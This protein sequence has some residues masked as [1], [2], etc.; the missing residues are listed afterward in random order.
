M[1]AHWIYLFVTNLSAITET[2]HTETD[3]D[4]LEHQEEQTPQGHLKVYP[5]SSRFCN[6]IPFNI[7]FLACVNRILF[8]HSPVHHGKLCC[9]HFLTAPSNATV[10]RIVQRALWDTACAFLW[11]YAPEWNYCWCALPLRILS[12]HHA[13]FPCQ[14]YCFPFS[15]TAHACSD[16]STCMLWLLTSV[17]CQHFLLPRLFMSSRPS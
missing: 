15:R 13:V 6:F 3:G 7:K 8:I 2:S 17:P 11:E 12:D 9:F 10:N 4:K 5:C 14:L 16:C 1:D